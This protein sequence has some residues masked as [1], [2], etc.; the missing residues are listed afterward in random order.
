[1]DFVATNGK[2]GAK[3]E[4]IRAKTL[5]SHKNDGAK[6]QNAKKTLDL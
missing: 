1:M 6:A 4:D 2:I 3:I 5:K